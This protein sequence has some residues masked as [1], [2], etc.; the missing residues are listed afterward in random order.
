MNLPSYVDVED[1]TALT[2][3]GLGGGVFMSEGTV[4]LADGSDI[5]SN[6][7]ILGGGVYLLT[8]TLTIAS[9]NSEIGYNTATGE[10]GGNL[11]PRQHH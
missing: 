7:A 9:A 3:D 10:G 4:S 6:D 1:N 5:M 8:S 11:C 2:G